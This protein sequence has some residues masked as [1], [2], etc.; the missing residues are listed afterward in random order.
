MSASPTLAADKLLE[1]G[2]IDRA[3]Y[4]QAVAHFQQYGGFIE[5]ALIDS[6]VL[7]E[8]D[9]LKALARIYRVRFVATSKLKKADIGPRV[10]RLIPPE[11]AAEHNVFPI[12]FDEESQALSIVTADPTNL[13]VEQIVARLSGVGRVVSYL[14]RPA[15]IK[16][17]IAK[18][19]RGDIHA[20]ASVDR[21]TIE[22][23]QSMMNIYERNLLDE[24]E[25]AAAVASSAA[26]SREQVLSEDDIAR[27][28]ERP[29]S[30]PGSAGGMSIELVRVLVSLIE[31][32]RAELSGH[33][34]ITST[35]TERMCRRI[36]LSDFVTG[37]TTLAALL[38]DMGKGAPFHLTAFNVAE[39]DGHKT[40][41]ESRFEVPIR[42]FESARLPP[43]TIGAI[44]HMYERADGRGFPEGRRSAE[45]PLGA[46]ILALS[47]TFADLTANPRNPFRRI[48]TTEEAM[49]VLQKGRGTVFDGALVD[50][51]ATVVAGDDLKRQ[52]LTGALTVLLV[53]PSPEAC[54]ILEMQLMTRGFKLRTAHKA[55]DALKILL[56]EQ[57][58][59]VI[60]EIELKPFDGFE[61]KRRLNED[62]RTNA[63]PLIYFTA[64]SG[65]EDVSKGF[66]LGAADFLAK[67]SSIDVVAA[68]LHKY[69]ERKD[70]AGGPVGV[71]GSLAEMSLPDL[72]QILAHS[73]KTG[74]LS[75]TS[76]GRRGEIHF[77]GGDI[78]DAMIEQ[79]RGDSAFFAMLRF[80]EGSFALDP[81]FTATNRV[82]R[83][84]AEM[85]L[86][87]GMRHLD[88][89]NR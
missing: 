53:E 82:I 23:F 4:Q 11:I 81:S 73:R 40:T 62:P 76:G 45:I 72:V 20:F 5:E 41:A 32:T 75:I 78:Y 34:V 31:S 74:R 83:D 70:A 17:A 50:L 52:L 58:H 68:K 10:L 63:I 28:G 49:A 55:D 33:S 37:A 22:Q 7:D 85:L 42:L 35:F 54:A 59:I 46:R 1:H 29:S 89:D 69:L 60:T 13:D 24:S 36:G 67:P 51:F 3:H 61:L 19:Y 65:G 38:H 64:R 47:D 71:S 6:R 18:F 77:V 80:R 48:L 57:I 16:A 15:A 14:A 86:L 26:S 25:M 8:A 84:T 12:L 43:E 21:E 87:E 79:L 9:L 39:W 44:R 56:K 2:V 88:E 30:V 66:A 27:R